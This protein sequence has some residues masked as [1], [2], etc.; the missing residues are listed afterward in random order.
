MTNYISFPGLGIEWIEVPRVAFT[1]LG[2]PIFWYGIIICIGIVLSVLYVCLRGKDE[3]ITTDDVI[4]YAIFLVPI[5][6]VCAR[7][8]F[9]LTSLDSFHSFYDVIA[10]WE[11]GLAIYGGIIGGFC[12]IIGVSLYKKIPIPKMLDCTAPGVFVGQIL[13]RWGNFFNAEA[14]GD[15][16][17]IDIL[18]HVIETPHFASDFPLRM[19]ISSTDPASPLARIIAAHPTF[20]YESVWNT[21]GFVILNV[22]YSKKKF[23]GQIA[24]MY[25]AWY[26]FGR[27][28]IDSLESAKFNALSLSLIICL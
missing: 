25:A 1:V 10:V 12:T 19:L 23:D 24:L 9:V 5:S 6:I 28:F 13:G 27:F 7:L 15:L 22:V 11:G 3:G 8:Y 16:T 21:V 17:K 18:G 2:K 20:L 26:G 4:D 14:Y